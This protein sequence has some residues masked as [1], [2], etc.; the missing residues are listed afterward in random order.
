MAGAWMSEK[1]RQLAVPAPYGSGSA[2]PSSSKGPD[3]I[4]AV[5]G[6]HKQLYS[7]EDYHS[8]TNA[9]TTSIPRGVQLREKLSEFKNENSLLG[10]LVKELKAS[11]CPAAPDTR[12]SAVI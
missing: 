5:R 7:S 1:P 8:Q 2:R 6:M 4:R 3:T 9:Y 10:S 12:H 11:R